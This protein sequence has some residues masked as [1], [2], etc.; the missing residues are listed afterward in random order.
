MHPIR[1]CWLEMQ[2]TENTTTRQLTILIGALIYTY[3][4][5]RAFGKVKAKTLAK[6]RLSKV[7]RLVG[8]YYY[9]V[10]AKRQHTAYILAS[11]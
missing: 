9:H 2:N 8:S 5:R 7:F 11:F 3:Y 6:L 10:K 1:Q 4:I